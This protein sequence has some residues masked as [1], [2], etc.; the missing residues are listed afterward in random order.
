MEFKRIITL[1]QNIGPSDAKFIS[2]CKEAKAYGVLVKKILKEDSYIVYSN[3]ESYGD[4]IEAG[5]VVEVTI[6]ARK[7]D[8]FFIKLILTYGT[9]EDLMIEKQRIAFEN[10]NTSNKE[11]LEE[12]KELRRCVSE[13]LKVEKDTN[14]DINHIRYKI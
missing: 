1:R 3:Q 10:L 13:L 8:S 2:S 14:N 7:A 4:I 12:I 11:M 5:S 9:A 6:D